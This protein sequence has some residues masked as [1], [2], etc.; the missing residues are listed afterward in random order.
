MSGFSLYIRGSFL[1]ISTAITLPAL[2]AD[3]AA[4]RGHWQCQEHGEAY[5]LEFSSNRVLL[6]NGISLNYQL[7]PDLMIVEEEYGPVPYYYQLQGE[8]LIFP[9]LD[10]SVARCQRAKQSPSTSSKPESQKTPEQSGAQTSQ[11]VTPGRNW[12]VYARPAGR[13]AWDTTDPQALVYKFSARWD[14]AT[15]NTLS[16]IYL[17]PDGRYE[18]AYEAGYS[19]TFED[20]GGYQTGAWGATGT[21]QGGGYWTIAGTLEQGVITL[22][23]NDGNS[24]IL[25]YRV[26]VSNG[27]YYGDYYFNGKLYTPKYIYR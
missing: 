25:N 23:G 11:T 3:F 24:Q 17:K 15:A 19:G 2:A 27:E 20:Q 14:S 8:A 26:Y 10:G 9:S 1:L 7:G 12:P 21:E 16:N 5:T 13:V 22:H 18:D 6:Y 4:L